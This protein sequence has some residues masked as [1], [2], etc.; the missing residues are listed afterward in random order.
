MSSNMWN[1]FCDCHLELSAT[2]V[3]YLTDIVQDMARTT[4]PRVEF[5]SH[6]SDSNG[7]PFH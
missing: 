1:F 5:L 4:I 6:M 3:C 2:F 7:R